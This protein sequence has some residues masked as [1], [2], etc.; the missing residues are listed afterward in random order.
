MDLLD[1]LPTSWMPFATTLDIFPHVGLPDHFLPQYRQAYRIKCFRAHIEICKRSE[2]MLS[3]QVCDVFQQSCWKGKKRSWSL[4][5]N[6]SQCKYKEETANN[7][8][9]GLTAFL[10]AFCLAFLFF[11]FSAFSWMASRHRW[12]SSISSLVG[13]VMMVINVWRLAS[14]EKVVQLNLSLSCRYIR[15]TIET[16]GILRSA[17]RRVMSELTWNAITTELD[18]YGIVVQKVSADNEGM[19]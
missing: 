8:I 18:C 10:L 6:S 4:Q 15:T 9:C 11:F 5:G 19:V 3:Y 17:N 13:G 16:L 7:T 14:E 2:R 1:E 12:T